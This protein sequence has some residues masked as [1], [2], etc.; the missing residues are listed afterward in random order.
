MISLFRDSNRTATDFS[1]C[2][3]SNR[4][5]KDYS[6][7]LQRQQEN[8][9]RLQLDSLHPTDSD[10]NFS[11][12]IKAWEHAAF[13]RCQQ[14][15]LKQTTTQFS[16]A[17]FCRFWWTF[18]NRALFPVLHVVV[19]GDWRGRRLHHHHQTQSH[20]HCH[21][22]GGIQMGGKKMLKLFFS[23]SDFKHQVN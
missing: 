22:S 19:P 18:Q 4:T 6:L 16:P 3:D 14:L 13:Q 21:L 5:A 11:E 1:L 17:Q 9:N 8:C 12:T 20:H 23:F 2:S 15:A 10:R 7:S